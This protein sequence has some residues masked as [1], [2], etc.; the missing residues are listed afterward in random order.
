MIAPH[1][2]PV[3]KLHYKKLGLTEVFATPKQNNVSD[4]VSDEVLW[5]FSRT[6]SNGNQHRG[7]QL[8]NSY[9]QN[10]IICACIVRDESLVL[11]HF[12][13]KLHQ[14]TCSLPTNIIFKNLT[15]I[16]KWCLPSNSTL[17]SLE[18]RV[19]FS[20]FPLGF[21]TVQQSVNTR[22]PYSVLLCYD[23]LN[24]NPEDS[25]H[26]TLFPYLF[27]QI[28]NRRLQKRLQFV[29][30]LTQGLMKILQWFSYLFR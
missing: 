12:A 7:I 14:A 1:S 18:K 26:F 4:Q 22:V 8:I 27:S 24:F 5:F 23:T 29:F 16:T 19:L 20:F 10:I 3:W 17:L 9:D 15:R 11:W 28:I 2:Y 30:N 6:K 13:I 21:S 25:G